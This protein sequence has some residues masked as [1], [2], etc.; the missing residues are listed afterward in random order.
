MLILHQ[1]RHELLKLFGKKRTYLGFLIFLVVQNCIIMAFKATEAEDFTMR[2]LTGNGYPAEEFLSALTIATVVLVPLAVF[3]LP[4]YVSLVGGEA[5]AKETE[6]GT[7]RMVL[8]RPISRGRLLL[9]KWLAGVVFCFALVACLALLGLLFARF[10]FPWKGLFVWLP[11]QDIFSV[12]T[13]NDGLRQYL[14]S[15]LL[16]IVQGVSILS[17]GFMFSCFDMKPAAATIL[18]LSF[19]FANFILQSLPYFESMKEWWFTSQLG[20]WQFVFAQ[21]IPWWRIGQSLSLLFGYNVTFLVIG[22][23]AF[24]IRDIKT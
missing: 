16:L 2:L 4:L 6:D 14:L 1:F 5:V 12:Y 10:W 17:L 24:Y 13:A 18:A 21:P 15:N 7:L 8:C 20:L 22:V 9:L 19:V 23:T 3:L 11:D